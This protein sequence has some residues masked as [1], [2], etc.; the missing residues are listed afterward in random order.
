MVN[1]PHLNSQVHLPNC[2]LGTPELDCL[3]SSEL[4]FITIF[5]GPNKSTVSKNSPIVVGVF[6]DPLLINGLHNPA[7]LLLHACMLRALPCKGRCL[8]SVCLATGLYATLLIH[9]TDCF[10]K[11]I[12]HMKGRMMKMSLTYN[13]FP[14]SCMLNILNVGDFHR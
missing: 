2:P 14:L 7:V 10:L 11:G 9:L 8:Q 13:R 12:H 6:F 4:S 1:T 5:H 3:F